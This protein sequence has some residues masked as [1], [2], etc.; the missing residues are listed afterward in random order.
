MEGG[1]FSPLNQNILDGIKK[2]VLSR[3]NLIIIK[4]I[5]NSGV[6]KATPLYKITL[7]SKQS[8]NNFNTFFYAQLAAIHPCL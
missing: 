6:V 5:K 7:L 3:G 4:Q 2:S 8:R 1:R